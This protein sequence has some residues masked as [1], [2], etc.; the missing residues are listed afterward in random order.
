[1]S[2]VAPNTF[3]IPISFRRCSIIK[4]ESANNPKHEMKIVSAA[5]IPERVPMRSSS[6]NF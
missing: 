6:S 3:L 2:V 1:M 4:V 5:K